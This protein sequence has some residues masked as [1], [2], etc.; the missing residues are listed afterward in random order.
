MAYGKYKN[1]NKRTQPDKV[2]RSKAFA[3]ASN[4]KYGGH[5]RG[6]ASMVH[7]FFD[8]KCNWSGVMSNQQLADDVHKPIT[9]KFKRRKVYSS[10]KDNIWVQ[11]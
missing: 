6:L 11:M 4:P 2:L 3:I 10:F 8:K 9:K 5:Q 7:N 1:F